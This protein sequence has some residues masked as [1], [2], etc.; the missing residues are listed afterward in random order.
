MAAML[1]G[2]TPKR[3]VEIAS[4]IDPG[5]GGPVTVLVLGG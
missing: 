1:C 5:T 2:K 3:A 4:K